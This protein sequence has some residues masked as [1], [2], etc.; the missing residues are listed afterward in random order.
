GPLTLK[1][2][3][4][5]VHV[6]RRADG[7]EAGPA[8]SS[9]PPIPDKPSI[10]V[11]PFVNMSEDASQ[12]YFVDGMTEDLITDLSKVPGLF[13]IARNSSFSYKGRSVDTRQIARELGVKFILEG[14]A[15]RAAGG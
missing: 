12:A 6:Y 11:L 7:G 15:R 14:S 4:R 3:D 5:P 1:N 8:T 9:S 13:V 2:I 10:A